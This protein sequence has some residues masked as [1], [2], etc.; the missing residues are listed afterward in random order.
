MADLDT[1]NSDVNKGIE[2]K[3]RSQSACYTTRSSAYNNNTHTN[4]ITYCYRVL[5]EIRVFCMDTEHVVRF[6]FSSELCREAFPNNNIGLHKIR[7][8]DHFIQEIM[9]LII[10]I[11]NSL[12]VNKMGHQSLQYAHISITNITLPGIL[13]HRLLKQT[14][15]LVVKLFTTWC[16]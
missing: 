13:H 9:I 11:N 3:T 4:D 5:G 14:L 2:Q 6:N 10:Y 15:H 1:M 16:F 7:H 8:S 12:Q